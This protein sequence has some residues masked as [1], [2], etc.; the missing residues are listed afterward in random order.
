MDLAFKS[1]TVSSS[2]LYTASFL[3]P[4]TETCRSIPTSTEPFNCA[5]L[6]F[7]LHS[8]ATTLSRTCFKNSSDRLVDT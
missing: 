1:Y 6:V 3:Q 4:F 7:W 5:P 8:V 2:R